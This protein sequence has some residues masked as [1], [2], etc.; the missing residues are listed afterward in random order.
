M[1]FNSEEL[2]AQYQQLITKDIVGK[3][4]DE[5]HQTML[6][7]ITADDIQTD[8]RLGSPV[9]DITRAIAIL[10]SEITFD[11][12]NANQQALPAFATD[13]YLDGH[14]FEAGLERKPGVKALGNVKLSSDVAV[15][16]PA[17]TTLID[18]SGQLVYETLYAAD[19]IPPAEQP[20]PDYLIPGTATIQCVAIEPGHKYNMEAGADLTVDGDLSLL[21][22]A[23]IVSNFI[24]GVDRESDTELRTRYFE[25]VGN[26]LG[27]GNKQDYEDWALEVNGVLAAKCLRA[28]PSAGHVTVVY[29]GDTP[30]ANPALTSR[31]LDNINKYASILSTNHAVAAT[32]KGI[33][34]KIDITFQESITYSLIS[35]NLTNIL[36]EYFENIYL[37]GED[38]KY[39][40]VL[41][42]IASVEGI[43]SVDNLLINGSVGNVI[44]GERE[45]P[46][47]G[48]VTVND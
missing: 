15:F 34:L 16:V 33:T 14:A 27:A 42:L 38:V 1:A 12:V 30:T 23:L 18:A 9:W 37:T 31:V 3:S 35:T 22:S 11:I 32:P 43:R 20:D 7:A 19:L 4:I 29:A 46:V 44:L 26:R 45:I 36:R 47:L 39:S 5:V 2:L 6:D 25:R 21:V 40:Q 13:T 24:D 17:G 28:T 41:T 10:A 48:T 8:T